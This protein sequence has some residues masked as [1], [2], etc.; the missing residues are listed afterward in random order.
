MKLKFNISGK[1]FINKKATSNVYG[2]KKGNWI[3]K[4]SLYTSQI[5]QAERVCDVFII[6]I[7]EWQDNISQH[8]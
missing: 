5:L 2:R 3:H 8:A 1:I 6:Q 7:A 4:W